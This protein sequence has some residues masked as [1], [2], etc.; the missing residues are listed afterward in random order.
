[1]N[2]SQ[3]KKLQ[4]HLLI[5]L[6]QF[7]EYCKIHHIKYSLCGGTLIGAVRH[8][9]FIPWDD[10]TDVMMTRSEYNALTKAWKMDPLPNYT[11]LTDKTDNVTF[12]GESG[13]WIRNDTIP[14]NPKNIFEVGT[15]LDIFIADA[16]PNDTEVAKIHFQKLH[17]IGRKYHSVIKRDKNLLISIFKNFIPS[18]NYKKLYSKL[19]NLF[20]LYNE[21][22]CKN[23][24]LALGSTSDFEKEVIP[25]EYFSSFTKLKFENHEFPAI[26]QYDAYLKNYY[27]DYMKLPPESERK[28]YHTRNHINFE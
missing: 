4:E 11:L 18:L 5:T 1:M 9:G 16:M 22:D 19:E 28:S 8:S 25:T 13:K 17:S 15:F 14:K 24:A 21:K 2:E 26:S 6:I 3:L 7:D 20:N 23:L 12:A 27:G 10:D